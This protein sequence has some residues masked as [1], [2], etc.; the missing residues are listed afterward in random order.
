VFAYLSRRLV[1][2]LGVLVA[3]MVVAFFAFQVLGDPTNQ[4]LP[5]TATKAQRIAYSV[6]HGYSDPLL[7]QFGRFAWHVVT[8]H[9]G[10]SITYG[11]SPLPLVMSALQRSLELTTVAFVLAVIGGLAFGFVAALNEGGVVDHLVTT[12]GVLALSFA[13]FWVGMVLIVVFA[14]QA[15]WLPAQGYGLDL[16]IILPAITLALPPLGR[17]AFIS[18]GGLRDALNQPHVEYSGALGLSARLVLRQYVLRSAM[19]PLMALGGVEWTRMLVGGTLVVETV[20]AWPGIGRLFVVGL[21]QHDL[22][23][24]TAILFISTVLV[25]GL[26]LLLDVVYAL[27]D[28]RIAL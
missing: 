9:F 20:F 8:L 26:N 14:V 2:G 17:I 22:P 10:Q 21:Q 3:V 12:L 18:R 25:L 5:L 4:L 6:A 11:G 13:E 15:G 16:H 1:H 24:V 7:V 27:I 23:L 19:L 28:P